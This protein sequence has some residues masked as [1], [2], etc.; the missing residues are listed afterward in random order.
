MI[1]VSEPSHY[2]GAAAPAA[3]VDAAQ[4]RTLMATFP[5]GVAVVTSTAPDGSPWGMTCSSVCGVSLRPPILLVCLREGSP[6][7]D[8]MLRL[9]TFAVNLL[10]ERA[11]ATAELFSSGAPD[12]FDRV[13]WRFTPS[14]GGPHLL[15]GTHMVADCRITGTLP[16]GDH[17]V[18]FGEVFRVE[19]PV[20]EP[21]P[22]LYGMRRYS[23]WPVDGSEDTAPSSSMR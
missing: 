17:S 22:L 13:A 18:V 1:P 21:R 15:E 6:T 2:G 16:V 12:R 10:H 14:Y 20:S 9:S 4:Y 19:Q 23:A 5:T 8:A 7:L 11:R 3:T